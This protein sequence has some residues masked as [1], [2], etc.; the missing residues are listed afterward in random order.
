MADE[1]TKTRTGRVGLGRGLATLIGDIGGGPNVEAPAPE[2]ARGQRRVAIDLIR[3]NPRNPRRAFAEEQ[4]NDLVAS[5]RER[6]IIQPIA[7]RPVTGENGVF[8]I[9]AGERRWRAAQA[10]GL[11]E[12][13]VLVRPLSDR[14]AAAA[15]LIENLQRADL[16]PI[17]E[18]EGYQRLM[19]DFG[20]T[21]D[22][23]GGMIG[24]SRSHVSNTLRLL[25]LPQSV[26]AELR[27]GV[28]TAGHARALLAHPDP[29]KA[30][31]AV[32]A[33]GLTVR[34]TEAMAARPHEPAQADRSPPSRDANIRAIEQTLTDRL[35][36][37]VSLIPAGPGGTLRIRYRSLDQLDGLLALLNPT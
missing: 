23:L 5:I 28:L 26:L 30:A 37:A 36:L 14:D 12:V 31:R 13:P 17:E 33:R 32:I 20:V 16:D 21:Q 18:A 15:A 34:Q 25:N 35:G 2:R 4:L 1:A 6:G 27:K 3:R 29:A 8:E 10:A 9:I 24:K 22:G 19:R 7:V 11:H